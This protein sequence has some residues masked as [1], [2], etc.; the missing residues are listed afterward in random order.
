MLFLD[1]AE[2]K[3][4]S[5]KYRKKWKGPYSVIEL[6]QTSQV[7]KIKPAKRRSIYVN[8]SKLKTYYKKYLSVQKWIMNG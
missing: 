8:I 7:V 3:G 4:I 6:N 5:N 1:E 2:K